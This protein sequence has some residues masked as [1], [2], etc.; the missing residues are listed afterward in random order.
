M[1]LL[2][3]LLSHLLRSCEQLIDT[4]LS[5][6][7]SPFGDSIARQEA[8]YEQLEPGTQCRPKSVFSEELPLSRAPTNMALAEEV[9]RITTEFEYTAEDVNRGVK[10]FIREMEEGLSK[11]GTTLSQIP[12][13]VT[14]VPTGTEKVCSDIWTFRRAS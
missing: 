6:R 8:Y 4:G 10:E 13:Y 11:Q 3:V 1:F 7:L 9:K 14:S 12:T 2:V 5:P